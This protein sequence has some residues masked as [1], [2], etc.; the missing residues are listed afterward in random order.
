M[1]DALCRTLAVTGTDT[2]IGKTVVAAALAARA[3]ELGLRVAA[4]KPI[5]SGIGA[6]ATS[7]L[8]AGTT[9]PLSD[10][11][12]LARAAGAGDAIALVGPIALEEPLAPMVA[13]ERAGHPIDVRVLDGARAALST[14]R[15]LLLVEGAGGILSPITRR[16]SFGEL[17]ARWGASVVIVAGNR[18]GVLNHTLLTVRA[19]ESLGLPVRAVV[20]TSLSDRDPDLAEATNYD[21]LVSLLPH[22]RVHRFAWVDRVDEPAALADAAQHA[23]LDH[24]LFASEF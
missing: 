2:G 4:M 12:R 6:H 11:A 19:A 23:G 16:F 20:L 22:C 3:P 17:F 15:E 21:A 9:M 5:E 10:S 14:G 13:A 7:P 18:L 8:A 1:V 24:V